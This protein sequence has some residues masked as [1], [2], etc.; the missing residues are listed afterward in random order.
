MA[1]R[2]RNKQTEVGGLIITKALY[3]SARVLKRQDNSEES[4]GDDFD[5]QI[6]DVTIPLNFL[7]N[8]LG[9]LKV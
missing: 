4:T 2:K 8:E 1:N 6:I 3:G 7:V 9:Q 5:S